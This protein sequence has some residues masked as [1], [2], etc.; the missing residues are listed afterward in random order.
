MTSWEQEL[1]TDEPVLER[2]LRGSEGPYRG[3]VIDAQT[4][5]PIKEVIVVALWYYHRWH[6]VHLVSTYHDALEV[7][8]DDQGYFIIDAPQIER[9]APS[10]TKFPEFVLFKPGYSS[11][12]GSLASERE[13]VRRKQIPLLGTVELERIDH[14]SKEEQGYNLPFNPTNS[15]VPRAKIPRFAKALSDHEEALA[16]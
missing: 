6:P 10:R 2:Y 7:V 4:K 5:K 12:R 11:F 1:E 14:L 15:H 13:L 9:R 16:R 3:R 8:T